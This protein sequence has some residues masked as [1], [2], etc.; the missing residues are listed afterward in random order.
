MSPPSTPR[1]STAIS[2]REQFNF[3]QQISPQPTPPAYKSFNEFQQ[4]ILLLN[5]GQE[6]SVSNNESF[7]SVVCYSVDHIIPKFEIYVESSLV[8][9]IRVFGWLLN[10]D[11]EIYVKYERCFS[12]VTLSNL[13]K[14]LC[15]YTLC[16][17]SNLPDEQSTMYVQK[18][19]IPCKFSFLDFIKSSCKNRFFQTEYYRSIQCQMLVVDNQSCSSCKK[20]TTNLI[21]ENNRKSLNSDVPA[22]VNAPLSATST[23]RLRLSLLD[24]RLNSLNHKFL[25]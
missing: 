3:F 8:F 13:V 25:K 5:L 22:H 10:N 24:E 2:K 18:H 17:G 6:W 1:S 11:H 4:R 16:C 9:T 15:S 19:V 21:S 14:D 20:Y 7:S 23:S 12:N